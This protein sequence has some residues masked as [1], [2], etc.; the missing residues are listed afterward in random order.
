MF[1]V[2]IFI[3][4]SSLF[5][6]Q[7]EA[8]EMT[9][10]EYQLLPT[11]CRNQGNVASN[12]FKPTAQIE[13]QNKLG[14]DYIH[15]HHYCWGLVSLMRAY[16][17]GQTTAERKY[18]LN[19][20]IADF[21]YSINRSTPGF[22]LLPEM[23]TKAGQAYLGLQD[24]KNAEMAFKKAWEAN[25][26]YWPAYLWWAQRLIKQ[27]RQREALAVAEEGLKNAP[28]SKP[29]ERLIAEMHGSGKANRK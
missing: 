19:T 7:V 15:I 4:F 3:I 22:V 29:L 16:R 1:L 24:E 21:T 26:E 5:A 23:Y 2:V 8:V 14:N 18:R 6:N 28:T 25:P 10:E 9:K 13:W 17:A 12:Y 27:G 20:A 11:Y